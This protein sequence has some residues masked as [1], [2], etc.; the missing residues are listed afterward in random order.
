MKKLLRSRSI[1]SSFGEFRRSRPPTATEISNRD[2]IVSF[3]RQLCSSQRARRNGTWR[4]LGAER[5]CRRDRDSRAHGYGR[6]IETAFNAIRAH[7]RSRKAPKNN[8]RQISGAFIRFHGNFRAI[9]RRAFARDFPSGVDPRFFFFFPPFHVAS[10]GLCSL[11]S[12][13]LSLDKL[14]ALFLS[15]SALLSASSIVKEFK[16]EIQVTSRLHAARFFSPTFAGQSSVG[17]SR[18]IGFIQKV[19]ASHFSSRVLSTLLPPLL[20]SRTCEFNNVE[21]AGRLAEKEPAS[22]YINISNKQF[23]SN[24]RSSFTNISARQPREATLKTL[25]GV[26]SLELT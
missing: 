17:L 7:A 13:S 1:G 18:R 10:T 2:F 5:R 19:S 23:R 24:A 3:P 11:F 12:L 15:L 14:C 8:R 20:W 16:R 26:S 9:C 25:L 22:R 6:D 21:T 4:I